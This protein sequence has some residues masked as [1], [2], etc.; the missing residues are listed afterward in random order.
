MRGPDVERRPRP[1]SAAGWRDV[2]ATTTATCG[3]LVPAL[4]LAAAGMTLLLWLGA[5]A[6]VFAAMVLFGGASVSW[7]TRH[8]H[9]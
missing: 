6:A 3:L 1:R 9:C 5:P 2:T 8:L 7:R 4:V